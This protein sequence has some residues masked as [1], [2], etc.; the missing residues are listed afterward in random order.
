MTAFF[1]GDTGIMART[2]G[3][4]LGAASCNDA[5]SHER[6]QAAAEKMKSVLVAAASDHNEEEAACDRFSA[7]V[8]VGR[9]AVQSGEIEDWAAENAL[10]QLEDDLEAAEVILIAC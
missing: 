5:V 2:F 8:V 3:I 6:L 7:S 10:R 4:V 1:P 9:R